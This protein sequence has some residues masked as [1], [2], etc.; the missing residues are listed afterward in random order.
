MSIPS[1]ALAKRVKRHVIGRTHR[2]FAVAAPGLEKVC[3]NEL[4][5]PPLS[6]TDARETPGGVAFEGRIHDAYMAN[7][8]LRVVN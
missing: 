2:F 8:H 5:S 4:A 1:D 3:L 7:L 6:I